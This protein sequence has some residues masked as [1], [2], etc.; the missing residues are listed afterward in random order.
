MKHASLKLHLSLALFLC[1]AQAALALESTKVT[2]PHAQVTLVSEVD[3]V[4][5]GKA[6]RLGLHFALA[7]GWHI[8]WVNPGEA[9][10]PPR[11]DLGLPPGA[12]ASGFAWPTPLRIPEGPAMT[13]SYIGDVTLPLTV[14]PAA[15]GAASSFTIKAKASWLI[16]ETI[17]VPEEGEFSL[18]LPIGV[19]PAPSAQAPLFAAADERIPHPSPFVEKLSGD[20]VLSFS[21]DGISSSSVSDAWFFPEKWDVI[22]DAAPQKLSVAAGTLSLSL[23]PAKSFDPAVSLAGL[24]VL[25][26]ERGRAFLS[27]WRPA[28]RGEHPLGFRGTGRI[29]ATAGRGGKLGT[30]RRHRHRRA[31]HAGFRFSWRADP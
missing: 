19:A 7:K 14:T 11:L 18:D 26:D 22:D 30:R 8:Y 28:S 10:E 16:C 12:S 2:T 3:A 13:Y 21:S 27:N 23:K 5:P 20:G 25:K 15:S 24:L 29:A 17:C 31:H 9:G 4:Q 1:G 6:F